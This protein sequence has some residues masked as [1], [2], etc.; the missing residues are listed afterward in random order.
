MISYLNSL[1]SG[2]AIQLR[3]AAHVGRFT[4]SANKT[5][6]GESNGL[7]D[8]GAIAC[9]AVV[10]RPACVV[11][12][13]AAGV[14]QGVGAVNR[15]ATAEP[16]CG[17]GKRERIVSVLAQA[18]VLD[19][20]LRYRTAHPSRWL[21]VL[22]YHRIAEPRQ[23]K[24]VD[25]DVIDATPEQF[26]DQVRFL[27]RH[28]NLIGTEEMIA[29]S[30]GVLITFDDGYRDAGR[31]AAILRRYN[32]RAV[33]FIAT[34]Y[35]SERRSYWWDAI[36][37][38]VRA[39]RREQ[40]VLR[41]PRPLAFAVDESRVDLLRSVL[42]LVKSHPQIVVSTFLEEL[43]RATGVPWN[44]DVDRELSD[45]LIMSW[46]EIREL[47]AS[48]ME[49]ESHTRTHRVLKHLEPDEA[50][51]E[52]S[53]SR[54]DLRRELDQTP[55]TVAYP[56]GSSLLRRPDIVRAAHESGYVL[57]YTNCSGSNDIRRPPNP[58]DIH[59]VGMDSRFTPDFFR[60]MMTIP[61]FMYPGKSVA[62]RRPDGILH[63]LA[64]LIL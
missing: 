61:Q 45:R 51:V 42:R 19:L 36:A 39:T 29:Y 10:V 64:G 21:T 12:D 60:G 2:P 16:E 47:S 49:I 46:D 44:R 8:R 34:G 20:A 38:L 18:G 13:R 27:S 11:G 15:Q 43:S 54:D 30:R 25:P 24:T 57:G 40:I 53:R 37:Y 26:E 59:R 48:G 9:S 41:Y 7:R 50:V 3:A 62:A 35:P 22:T 5:G 6:V 63:N 17:K 33:Y 1:S 58:F 23:E 56:V 32:A 55:R 31:A 28:F 14:G 4:S 52:L